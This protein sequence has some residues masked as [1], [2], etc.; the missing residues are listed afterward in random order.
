MPWSTGMNLAQ[1]VGSGGLMAR[2]A[3]FTLLEAV[4][5]IAILATLAGL[6]VSQLAPVQD[7]SFANAARAE[8]ATLRDACV[9]WSSDLG[10]L[11]T[12]LGDLTSATPPASVP[13]GLTSWNP[14]LKRGW[15]GPYLT[16]GRLVGTTGLA[17]PWDDPSGTRRPYR[18][19][20]SGA[21]ATITSAGADGAFGTADDLMVT[22]P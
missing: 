6:A 21:S 1:P 15:R 19:S 4:I 9:R 12:T 7:D 22:L 16:S 8:L 17:D 20:V 3:G 5:V 14:D 18:Y 13:A 2:H 11:P 10:P